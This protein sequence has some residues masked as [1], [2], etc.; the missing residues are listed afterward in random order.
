[1]DAAI[2]LTMVITDDDVA[3]EVFQKHPWHLSPPIE[4]GV[5]RFLEL[6]GKA[7]S[8]ILPD[9]P[10][11]DLKKRLAKVDNAFL[12]TSLL[13]SSG[14]TPDVVICQRLFPNSTTNFNPMD[15]VDI[16][17]ALRTEPDIEVAINRFMQPDDAYYSNMWAELITLELKIPN[18]DQIRNS[19]RDIFEVT[20]DPEDRTNTIVP[21]LT[22]F[23]AASINRHASLFPAGFAREG[24]PNLATIVELRIH[25][26]SLIDQDE[27]VGRDEEKKKRPVPNTSLSKSSRNLVNTIKKGINEEASDGIRD[28]L[29]GFTSPRLQEEAT[30]KVAAASN[31]DLRSFLTA[32]ED[33]NPNDGD[34]DDSEG[35][36]FAY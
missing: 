26:F 6:K 4:G 27:R 24:S 35:V 30:M 9:A 7:V 34:D 11:A 3:A 28:F 20:T 2:G 25:A 32:E 22:A 36:T 19:F 15:G 33:D 10:K 8:E 23:E 5:D 13:E 17:E 14:M 21:D 31:R 1:L 16:Y 12:R 18:S 29:C